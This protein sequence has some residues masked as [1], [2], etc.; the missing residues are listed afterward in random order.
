MLTIVESELFT[1]LWPDYWTEHE[2]ADFVSWLAANPEAGEVIP[3]SG[4][5]RKI[6]WR[7]KGIGKRGGVRVIY[8]NR[9]KRGEIWLLTLYAK[10]A[11][12]NLPAHILRALMEELIDA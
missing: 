3:G 1:R 9:L 7:Q 2:R 12:E 8:F 11:R 10:S 5:C 6:R 4:G